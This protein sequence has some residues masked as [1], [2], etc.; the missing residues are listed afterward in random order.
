MSQSFTAKVT[1]PPDDDGM[2]GFQCPREECRPRYFKVASSPPASAP[3]SAESS[4]SDDETL[5]EGGENVAPSP[6]LAEQAVQMLEEPEQ[7]VPTD[8]TG[9]GAKQN[10]VYCP[11]CGHAADRQEF[12]TPEQIEYAHSLILRHFAGLIQ[13][14]LKQLE[15]RPDPRAL[16][17]VGISVRPGALPAIATYEETQLKQHVACPHCQTQYAV[18][19][20]SFTCPEC[21]GGTLLWHLESTAREIRTF[22]IMP[23]EVLA[24]L[25]ARGQEKLV[26]NALEDVVS[27]WEGYLKAL[28]IQAIRRR[29]D[30]Q[31]A[32][33]KEGH[34]GTTFQ[35]I[36]GACE[37]FSKDLGIDLLQPVGQADQTLLARA[38]NKRHVLTHNLGLVDDKF[39]AQTHAAQQVGQEI[40]VSREETSQALDIVSEVL[41]AADERVRMLP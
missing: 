3:G 5:F 40:E 38:F 6:D 29:Y 18:Y 26:E 21:G 2:V 11:Y 13:Q 31:A 10:L 36:Q 4:D 27:F 16:V 8:A 19:G 14:E 15:R 35:R 37:R 24:Y 28:Y 41:R 39:L 32:A 9:T 30:P 34:I 7:D 20:I 1:I 22:L 12:F 33:N 23:D 17:S 25:D